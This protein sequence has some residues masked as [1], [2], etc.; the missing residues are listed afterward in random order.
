ME[1]LKDM[2]TAIKAGETRSIELS[3]KAGRIRV[4]LERVDREGRVLHTRLDEWMD[5]SP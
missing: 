3:R 2:D 4:R 1:F 5:I